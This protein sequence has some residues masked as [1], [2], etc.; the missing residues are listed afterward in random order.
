MKKEKKKKLRNNAKSETE[1]HRQ[2]ILKQK[3]ERKKK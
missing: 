1:R 3:A 2:L